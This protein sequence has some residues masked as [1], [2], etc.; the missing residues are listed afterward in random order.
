MDERNAVGQKSAELPGQPS[1][2]QVHIQG[3]ITYCCRIRMFGALYKKIIGFH[4]YPFLL[5]QLICVPSP[6]SNPCFDLFVYFILCKSSSNCEFT[7]STSPKVGVSPSLTRMKKLQIVIQKLILSF[8][9]QVSYL[10]STSTTESGWSVSASF[11][12]SAGRCLSNLGRCDGNE[13]NYW[14]LS[15]LYDKNTM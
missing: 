6:Q 2:C 1:I 9:R 3:A 13:V 8:F 14:A 4:L 7:M 10:T 15:A 5:W 12:A 11:T